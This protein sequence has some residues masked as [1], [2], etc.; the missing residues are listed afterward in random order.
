MHNLL[1]HI[2]NIKNKFGLNVIVAINKFVTDTDKEIEFLQN[3]LKEEG[4]NMSL[5]E[6]W[7]K[8]EKEQ[9]T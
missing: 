7:Q 9:K 6:A 5:V 4:I 3:K 1:R 2:D 8:V